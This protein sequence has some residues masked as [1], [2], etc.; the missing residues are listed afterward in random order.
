[1]LKMGSWYL[2]YRGVLILEIQRCTGACVIEEIQ[3]DTGACAIEEFLYLGYR[4]V[5]V[6]V[7]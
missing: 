6:L 1:M 5:L 2:C 7:L 4:G 3:R